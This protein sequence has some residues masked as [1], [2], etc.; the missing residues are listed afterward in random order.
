M[1]IIQY[2]ESKMPSSKTLSLYLTRTFLSAF[3]FIATGIF[4]SFFFFFSF[5][6]MHYITLNLHVFK[7][8][9]VVLFFPR[10]AVLLTVWLYTLFPTWAVQS[11]HNGLRVRVSTRTLCSHQRE[12]QYSRNIVLLCGQ[13]PRPALNFYTTLPSP[14]FTPPPLVSFHFPR[15]NVS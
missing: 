5:F 15:P 13:F 11:A 14:A 10:I 7:H 1:Q 12:L 8:N 4:F 3:N 6:A 2:M 9:I